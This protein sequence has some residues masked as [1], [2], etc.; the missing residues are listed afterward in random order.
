MPSPASTPSSTAGRS[1]KMNKKT[2]TIVLKLT[3]SL[4]NRFPGVAT[5]GDDQEAKSKASSSSPTSSPTPVGPSAASVDNAS[6]PRSSPPVAEAAATAESPKKKPGTPSKTGT[7]R[8]AGSDAGPK[9]ELDQVRRRRPDCRLTPGNRDDGTVDS[10][11]RSTGPTT[12]G[13]H[14]L[15]PKANQG[16]INAGLRALDR[17]GKPCRTAW[18]VRSWRAPP[19]PKPADVTMTDADTAAATPADDKNANNKDNIASSAVASERSNAGETAT[20]SFP[21]NAESSPAPVAAAA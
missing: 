13:T 7:K 5:P 14:K 10:N 20:P 8:A 12:T 17:T 4:L 15:G 11:G 3:S 21:G 16:A 6:E 18:Q 9:P 1:T 2:K 19:R